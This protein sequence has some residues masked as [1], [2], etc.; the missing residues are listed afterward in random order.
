MYEE[1]Y[2]LSGPPFKLSPD[3]RFFYR[4]HGH[5]KA[6]SYLKFGLHQGEGFIVITGAVGTGKSTL[7]SQLFS[8]LDSSEVIAAQIVTTQIEA[9]D[10]VR[11]ILSAFDIPAPNPD[12]ASLLR[13]F[14]NFLVHQHKLS[15]R[16]L[17]IVDEA[18]NLPMRTIE[19]LRMLSNFSVGGQSLFQSFLLGQP[20]FNALLADP[21]LEQLRQ[22]VIASYHLEP[23][24]GPE[25][26]EYIKHRLTM[27]GWTDDPSITDGAFDRV[28]AET[29]GIPRRINTLC[30]RLL[31]YGTLEEVHTLD[32]HAVDEVVEDLRKEVAEGVP[33]RRPGSG[34]EA[35][36]ALSARPRRAAAQTNGYAG[37]ASAPGGSPGSHGPSG[38]SPAGGPGGGE[39]PAGAIPPELGARL[40]RLE[41]LVARHE[42]V[43]REI[44]ETAVSY[45]SVPLLPR[46]RPDQDSGDQA[47]DDQASD[48]DD[49]R[50]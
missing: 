5:R 30:N 25:T 33:V 19:E 48:D 39:S 4:S 22:R 40:D 42:Q 21:S 9:D 3:H 18:Q 14:E 31:L 7:A 46:R 45:L 23:M 26:R 11:M 15:R 13:A 17:L 36:P 20:Q 12:K 35:E 6:M 38:D 32:E 2:G 27:V 10:A 16:V 28:F 47:S 50:D 1:F 29:E 44:L 43:L 24:T 8:E 34:K 41:M 37:E 49:Q